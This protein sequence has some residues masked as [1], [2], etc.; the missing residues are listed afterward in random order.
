MSERMNEG[1]I[2][3]GSY[4]KCPICGKRFFTSSPGE[5]VYKRNVKTEYGSTIWF[6]CSW[7]CLR[8]WDED[9]EPKPKRNYSARRNK[10]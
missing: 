1:K 9:H 8:K 5:Y 4:H 3:L 7:T 2:P 10:K 6:Y